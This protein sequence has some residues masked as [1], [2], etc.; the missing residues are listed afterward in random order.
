MTTCWLALMTS[1]CCASCCARSAQHGG[2]P[3]NKEIRKGTLFGGTSDLSGG[4]YKL[5]NK[6]RVTSVQ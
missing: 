3:M 1:D 5:K 2:D 6:P 4:L